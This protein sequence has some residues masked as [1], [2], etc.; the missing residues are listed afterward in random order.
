MPAPMKGF[1]YPKIKIRNRKAC[2]VIYSLGLR[3][4][5]G[6]GMYEMAWTGT[7]IVK[8]LITWFRKNIRIV[9]YN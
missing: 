8:T 5:Q 7:K 3:I 4:I 6:A 9:E 1:I 2:C